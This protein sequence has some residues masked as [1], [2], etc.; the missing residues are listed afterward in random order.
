MLYRLKQ[1]KFLDCY[2]VTQQERDMVAKESLF[3]DVIKYQDSDPNS[4]KS[5]DKQPSLGDY[6][7][8]LPSQTKQ[9]ADENPQGTLTAAR[10]RADPFC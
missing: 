8:P 3:Y 5:A 2:E 6:Y 7:T 4:A 1:L 10:S 9:G